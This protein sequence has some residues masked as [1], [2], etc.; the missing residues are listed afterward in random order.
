M[1]FPI[2]IAASGTYDITSDTAR[3]THLAITNN[4]P[5]IVYYGDI[6]PAALQFGTTASSTNAST[7]LTMGAAGATSAIQPGMAITGENSTITDGTTVL[8]VNGDKVT[9]SAAALD[10]ATDLN[11][12]FTAPAISATNGHPILLGETRF[13]TAGEIAAINQHGRRIVADSSGAAIIV[14]KQRS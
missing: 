11:P 4:G 13:F 1:T 12:I 3:I 2:T 8:A 9:L 5:G 14:T 10:T 7:T 6:P